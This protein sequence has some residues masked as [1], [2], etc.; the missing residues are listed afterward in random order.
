LLSGAVAVLPHTYIIFS[1]NYSSDGSTAV[2]VGEVDGVPVAVYILV[3]NILQASSQSASA[4]QNLLASA[5][6]AAKLS[7][8]NLPT[9]NPVTQVPIGSFMQ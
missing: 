3:S 2:I 8:T 6:M 4:L 9:T 5:M 1:A 7:G